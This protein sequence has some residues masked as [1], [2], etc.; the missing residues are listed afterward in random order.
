MSSN[1]ASNQL[2]EPMVLVQGTGLLTIFG[3]ALLYLFNNNGS[4]LAIYVALWA[5]FH[6][7]EYY[8]TRTYLPRTANKWLFLLFGAVGA[9]NLFAVHMASVVEYGL[10]QRYWKY[11]GF[12]MLGILFA[13]SGITVRALA[14]KHCGNSFS[15]YI[16]TQ[17]PRTLVTRGV[18]AWVRHPSYL[19]F[20]LYV[21]GMQILFGNLVIY[22]MSMA[23]LFRFFSVRIRLEESVLINNL[24]GEAYEKYAER[25]SALVPFIY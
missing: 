11:H 3:S 2:L 6:L 17:Q 18:Y 8:V 19:G 23:I 10:T 7:T 24:Y 13:L 21:M 12:P 14:I 16:E 9:G 25:V 22:V 15:H 5:I 20:I 1:M 4:K